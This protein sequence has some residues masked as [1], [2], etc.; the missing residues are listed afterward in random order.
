[1]LAKSA[2]CS[3]GRRYSRAPPPPSGGG[4]EPQRYYDRKPTQL[5]LGDRVG[6]LGRGGDAGRDAPGPRRGVAVVAESGTR[7]PNLF[8]TF[9]C[10]AGATKCHGAG[11]GCM[12]ISHFFCSSFFPFRDRALSLPRPSLDPIESSHKRKRLNPDR[13]RFSNKKFPGWPLDAARTHKTAL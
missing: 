10:Q 6:P 13:K 8:R 9:E 3:S 7:A 1:M 12:A 4:G 5:G 11:S 2:H